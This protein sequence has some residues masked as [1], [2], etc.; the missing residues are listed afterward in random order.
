[1]SFDQNDI[2]QYRI[3]D[4]E[5]D[6]PISPIRDVHKLTPAT[7][8]DYVSRKVRPKLLNLTCGRSECDQEL[9]TFRPL[10]TD[11]SST[12][13]VPCT[14]CGAGL[15]GVDPASLRQESPEALFGALQQEWIRH[16]FFHLPLTDRIRVYA[17]KNGREGLA[18]IAASQLRSGRMIGYSPRWDSQ[19]TAM[20]RGTIVHWAR[21]AV[22]C[23]CR[24]CIAYWHGIPMS[25]TLTDTDINYLQDL[26]VKYLDLRLPDLQSAPRKKPNGRSASVQLR[27]VS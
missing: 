18:A 19:Q 10:G 27:K 7:I 6:A 12:G 1:M 5:A 8:E 11:L 4:E 23:C 14:R 22:A 9:H 25:A 13:I 3:L 15:V 2:S 21:H 20:L 16:F 26:I 24:R 17:E